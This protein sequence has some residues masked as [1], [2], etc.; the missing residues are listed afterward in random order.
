MDVFFN[1]SAS[2]EMI[3]T[4]VDGVPD[5]E[6]LNDLGAVWDYIYVALAS[7]WLIVGIPGNLMVIISCIVFK[8]MHT[9]PMTL[10]TNLAV[11]DALVASAN[12]ATTYLT[13]LYDKAILITNSSLCTFTSILCG[14]GCV[15]SMASICNIAINR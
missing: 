4:A 1:S 6:V 9:I 14:L 15:C 3:E 11:S 2:S 10:A 5:E 8:E 7:L 13:I 12:V